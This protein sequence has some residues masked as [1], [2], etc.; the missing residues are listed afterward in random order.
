ME[1][2]EPFSEAA[3]VGINVLHMNCA[4]RTLAST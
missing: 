3:V 4:A 2:K 1:T